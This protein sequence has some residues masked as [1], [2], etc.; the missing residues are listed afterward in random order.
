L[1]LVQ[2]YRLNLP[3]KP[4]P[5]QTIKG[6]VE[7]V[8]N[9]RNHHTPTHIGCRVIIRK[10]ARTCLNPRVPHIPLFFAFVSTPSLKSNHKSTIGVDVFR[11][12]VNFT[13]VSEPLSEDSAERFVWELDKRKGH[14][15]LQ[16]DSGGSKDEHPYRAPTQRHHPNFNS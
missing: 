8:S 13:S 7:G 2:L 3:C 16:H 15:S 9:P 10:E 12:G 4:Y 6:G 5:P 1:S 11:H 14:N